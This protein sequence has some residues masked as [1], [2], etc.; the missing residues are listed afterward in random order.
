M[1]TFLLE[2]FADGRPI[3]TDGATVTATS[4][5]TAM[6]RAYIMAKPNIRHRPKQVTVRL[7]AI[8]SVSV[9]AEA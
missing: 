4:F 5:A 6:R 1:K 7:T 8:K 2:V 9:Q 3:R